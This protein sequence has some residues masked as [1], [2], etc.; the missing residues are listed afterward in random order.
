MR[1]GD[2][3]E[4]AVA[5]Q[6]AHQTIDQ[7]RIDQRLVALDVDDV[8]KLRRFRRDFATRSVPLR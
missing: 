5:L 3:L 2:H 4:L 1:G 8:R 6:F 7:L